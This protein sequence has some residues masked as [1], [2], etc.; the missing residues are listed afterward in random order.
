MG[1]YK[2]KVVNCN[3]GS[4]TIAPTSKFYLKYN[5]GEHV[6]ALEET[7]GVMLFQT[8]EFA[9]AYLSA[10]Q[11]PA[12]ADRLIKRVIPVGEPRF[13]SK[14]AWAMSDKTLEM[15]NNTTVHSLAVVSDPPK[16]T[17]CYPEVIVVD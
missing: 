15:F 2:Y 3:G 17:V 12:L 1:K 5:K 10:T 9:M 13:P 7:L 8:R 16:G 14:I 4:C 6:K 11:D